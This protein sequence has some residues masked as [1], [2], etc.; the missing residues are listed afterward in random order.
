[1]AS[2]ELQLSAALPQLEARPE[3]E[4]ELEVELA[5]GQAALA[6]SRVPPLQVLSVP[7]PPAE[8]SRLE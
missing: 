7:R 6:L 3:R 5:L 8:R 2:A 4:I 1:M